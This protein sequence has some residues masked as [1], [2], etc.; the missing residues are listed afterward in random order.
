MMFFRQYYLACLSHASYLIGDTGT[1]RAVVVDPQRDV[2]Q[3]VADAEANG[4]HIERIFETHFHADFLSGHLELQK[5][6]GADITFGVVGADRT[7]FPVVAMKDGERLS[8]GA[9]ILEVRDTPGHTPESISIVVYDGSDTPY[10]V[11][12]G[13]T[14]FIGDVGRPDLLS[15]FGASA[16]NLGRQLYHSLHHKLLTLPDTTKVYPAHGAGSA[17]GKNLSTETVSTIGEQLRTNYALAPMSE[18]EFV[19]VVTEGQ[20]AAPL[21]FSFAAVRNRL[22]RDV[23]DESTGTTMLTIDEVFRA[24]QEGAVIIDTRE[25]AEFALGHLKGSINV[26]L[27][28]RFAEYSGEVVTSE[29]PIVLVCPAGTEDEARIRLGRIGFDKVLGAL[30]APEVAFVNNPDSV[31]QASRLTVEQLRERREALSNVQ[32]IDVRGPGETEAGVIPGAQLIQLP[33]LVTRLGDLDPQAPTVVYC[34]GGY[35]SSIAAS[36]LRQRGFVDVS[37]IIGGFGA[38]QSAGADV[39]VP[40]RTH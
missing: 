24:Q 5:V 9:V 14:L 31:V 36:T 1:G 10:G 12:T 6:T 34:A 30:D 7:E 29:T 35:R 11:L 37:D 38:W 20:A 32:V 18:D 22:K 21:Y 3:Y 39:S 40:Q 17:C 27:S 13:D 23:F 16:E 4:L 33:Q 28:G 2:A 25:P 19:K 15:A 8:L 26:G